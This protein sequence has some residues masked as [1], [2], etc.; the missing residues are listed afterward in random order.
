M[1]TEEFLREYYACPHRNV[2]EIARYTVDCGLS[3][4]I[5]YIRSKCEDCGQIFMSKLLDGKETKRELQ[6]VGKKN[7]KGRKRK[8][9]SDLVEKEE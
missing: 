7:N 6:G 4:D 3:G 5:T 8:S 1:T 9:I 2:R